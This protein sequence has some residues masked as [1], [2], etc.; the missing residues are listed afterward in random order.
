MPINE[1]IL[2]LEEVTTPDLALDY[3]PIVD[4]NGTPTTKRISPKNLRGDLTKSGLV[5]DPPAKFAVDT[6][7]PI[8]RAAAALTISRIHISGPNASPGSELNINL[9]YADN[10]TAW[11]NLLR[12]NLCDT[13]SGVFTKTSGFERASVPAGKYIHWQTDS[14]PHADWLWFFYEI[15]YTYD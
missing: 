5:W 6:D 14:A 12:I 9:R 3:I 2:E 10:T 4:A 8:F 15:Y 7:I 11:D 1:T 13:T